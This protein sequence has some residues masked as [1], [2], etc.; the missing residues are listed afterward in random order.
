MSDEKSNPIS[1]IVSFID[2]LEIE[3][4]ESIKQENYDYAD[5][6]TDKIKEIK[7]SLTFERKKQLLYQHTIEVE[8]LEGSYKEEFEIFNKQWDENFEKFEEKSKKDEEIVNQRHAKEMNELYS[9]LEQKLPKQVKYSKQYLDLKSQEENLVKL[10]RFKEASLLKKRLDVMDKFDTER[11]NKEKYEKIKS[12]SVKTA[13]KHMMEKAAL[14]KKIEI[15]Y[16]I[17]K[18]D[19]QVNLEKLLLKYKN[20]KSELDNQ[21]KQE[22]LFLEN[23]NILKKSKFLYFICKNTRNYY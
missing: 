13:N 5:E 17:L 3:K 18:R 21:Q 23:E 20:R 7:K 14:K 19:R 12:Q 8:S 9:F 6:I 4:S 11:F 10:Q 15:N 16:Q 1:E 2:K 22:I